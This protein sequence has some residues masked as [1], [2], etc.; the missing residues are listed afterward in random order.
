MHFFELRLS[1]KVGWVS[2]NIVSKRLFEFNVNVFRRYKEHFFKVTPMQ[3]H[4]HDA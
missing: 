1:R 3:A 2:L 4:T